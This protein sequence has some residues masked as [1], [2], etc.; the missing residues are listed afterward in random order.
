[1]FAYGINCDKFKT[2]YQIFKLYFLEDTD[3]MNFIKF[4]LAFSL[5]TFIIADDQISYNE[6]AQSESNDE[7]NKNTNLE[8]AAEDFSTPIDFKDEYL[9]TANLGMSIPFGSNLKSKF[10]SG[11]NIKFNILT[12]FGFTFLNKD[13]KIAAGVDIISCKA[14]EERSTDAMGNQY[15]DYS[16]TNIGAKLVTSISSINLFAG[17]GLATSSGNE[18][19]L[20]DGNGDGVA[21]YNEY[22]M[23]SAYFS[24][25]GSYTLPL[26]S[27]FE[28]ID[29]GNINFD[30][31]NLT[32]S[33]FGEGVMIMAAPAEEG[34]SDI[35]NAGISIGYPIL[36]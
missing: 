34:T 35:I 7:E 33:L 24:A 30:I 11:A 19:I 22:S 16:A 12:P 26:S 5:S 2:Q 10:T 18:M 14:L 6:I 15:T 4:L 9:V 13:F 8:D 32:I 25:G 1:M 20:R 28:K 29:M 23:T 27:L 3:I 31:S 36:F 21:T 17:T